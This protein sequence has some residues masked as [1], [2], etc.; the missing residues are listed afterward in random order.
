MLD[1]QTRVRA[2]RAKE[3]LDD[4]DPLVATL[5]AGIARHHADD[6]WF[7][8]TTAFHELNV[9]FAATI[10]AELASEVVVDDHGYRPAFLGHI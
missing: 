10:R 8:Q 3:F 4:A 1:R 6:D 2:K 7:H 9:C 5:A